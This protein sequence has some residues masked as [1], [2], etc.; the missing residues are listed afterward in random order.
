MKDY[1]S[2]FI[3]SVIFTVYVI[4][5]TNN[6]LNNIKS[7]LNTLYGKMLVIL[8][9]LLTLQRNIQIGLIITLAYILAIIDQGQLTQSET[10][11]E[12]QLEEFKNFKKSKNK[13]KKRK[14]E[15]FQD[16][17]DSLKELDNEIRKVFGDSDSEEPFK[18]R[19]RKTRR[20]HKSRKT[21][22]SFKNGRHTEINELKEKLSELQAFVGD[23]PTTI[24]AEDGDDDDLEQT[25]PNFD[26]QTGNEE[27]TNFV[28]PFTNYNGNYSKF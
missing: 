15:K 21:H 24:P 2:L 13:K 3:A 6:K 17:G 14:K 8:L 7:Y 10:Q 18:N 28:E 22:E 23:A 11:S 16:I 19:K 1:T 25:F 12:T 5:L 27:F 20:A 26:T 9:I 4:L